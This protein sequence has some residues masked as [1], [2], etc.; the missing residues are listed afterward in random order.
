MFK[1]NQDRQ[2]ASQTH[3]ENL[4]KNLEHRIEVARAN[5]DDALVQQ[6]EAEARYL[7]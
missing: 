2:Q 1:R 3:R 5:G 7:Q 4:R 6:L